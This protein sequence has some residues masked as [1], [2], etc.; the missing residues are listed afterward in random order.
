MRGA[1]LAWAA[2]A[3]AAF[4]SVAG[5]AEPDSCRLVRM[6][7]PGWSDIGA[8]TAMAGTVL[9][10]L[11]YEQHVALLG[12]Q[13]TF[14]ALAHNEIDV[15]LGN[16]MPAQKTLIAP[17]L[18][19]GSIDVLTPNLAD[20]KFTLAVPTAIAEQGVRSFSDLARFGDRFDH[21]LY[22]IDAGSPA[23]DNILR[24][25]DEHAFGLGDWS[26]IESSEQGMLSQVQR[27]QRRDQWIVFLAWEPHPMNLRFQIT[28]LD[29]G[30]R[31]FGPDF[32]H[33]TIN[34][35]TRKG[36]AAACGNLGR[37]FRQMHFQAHDEDVVMSDIADHKIEAPQAAAAYLRNRPDLLAA[38]L[39]GVT[40]RDGR[41]GL[42]AVQAALDSARR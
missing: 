9:S 39:D 26:I 29:G 16:W 36:F 28:Y 21:R 6:S 14:Y 20:G 5:A 34:T 19:D 41:D 32:G 24:M 42:A 11:G 35:L 25:L 37:L 2:L 40:T 22:G 31:Y 13:V 15:F 38:W 17:F 23:N 8:T 4:V 10:A 12:V 1:R 18:K 7:D 33:T 30:D 3:A 27:A